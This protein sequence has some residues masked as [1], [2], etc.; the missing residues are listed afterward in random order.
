MA[1]EGF[2][3][4]LHKALALLDHPPPGQGLSVSGGCSCVPSI[5]WPREGTHRD[6]VPRWLL[7]QQRGAG[8]VCSSL[9]W[10]YFLL[11]GDESGVGAG[12]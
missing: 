7:W 9:G 8:S 4:D 11:S 6:T 10:S 12:G 5:P 2:G 1:T 3:Q